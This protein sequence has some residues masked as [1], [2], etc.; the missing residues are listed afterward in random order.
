MIFSSHLG[1]SMLC[2]R[3]KVG[4]FSFC[5]QE[6]KYF[7]RDIATVLYGPVHG[8]YSGGSLREQ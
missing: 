5:K 1:I 4:D 7:I 8:S 6:V 3:K 2:K